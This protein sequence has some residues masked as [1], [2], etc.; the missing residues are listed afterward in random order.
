MVKENKKTEV[1][2]QLKITLTN[3]KPPIWRRFIVA[4]DMK[5]PD[6]HKIIQTIMGWTNSHLH[7]FRINNQSYSLPE[8][9]SSMDIVD[10]RKIKLDGVVIR[11]NQKFYYDYDFGDDWNHTI[12]VE[13]IIP[14]DA[15][16]KY[17]I[18]IAGKRNCP[19]E[20]CGGVWGYED[21]LKIL[22]DPD[23]EEYEEIKEWLSDD[24]DP[25]RFD[26]EE[27]NEMLKKKI[28]DV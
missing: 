28:T 27:I 3:S 22:L 20:D 18:C 24:F 8:E 15:N 7:Q 25:E 2:Y 12:I 11:E 14:R 9:E 5:L 21:L 26:I 16:I 23:H 4:S 13:K 10:Y 17:P 19:P 1:M 6:L